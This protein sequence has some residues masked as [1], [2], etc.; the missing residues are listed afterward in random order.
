VPQG[1][2][3]TVGSA[4]G[5]RRH[6]APLPTQGAARPGTATADLPCLRHSQKAWL[7]AD[8]VPEIAQARLR[9][10]LE[11]RVVETYSHVAPE[12]DRRLLDGPETRWHAAQAFLHP[13][14][15]ALTA[16]RSQPS[17]RQGSVT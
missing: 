1:A 6:P 2:T 7:I 10:H 14:E 16:A 11:D 13:H 12:V 8:G 9:H 15:P 4:P 17:G 5:S 3:C